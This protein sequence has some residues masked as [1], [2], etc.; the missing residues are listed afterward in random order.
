MGLSEI[1]RLAQLQYVWRH[2]TPKRREGAGVKPPEI[3]YRSQCQLKSKRR[4]APNLP[5]LNFFENSAKHR[6]SQDKQHIKGIYSQNIV[7][8]IVDVILAKR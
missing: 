4:M 6:I 3:V 5:H 1:N 2:E 8:S 7:N